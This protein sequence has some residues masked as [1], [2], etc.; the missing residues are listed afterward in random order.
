MVGGRDYGG[1]GEIWRGNRKSG[2]RVER[3]KGEG[4]D[5]GMETMLRIEGWEVDV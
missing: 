2:R 3:E 5:G 1:I 4:R